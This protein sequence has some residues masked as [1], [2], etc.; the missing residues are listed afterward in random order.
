MMA[1]KEKADTAGVVLNLHQSYSPADTEADRERFG[2]VDPLVHLAEVG[3]LAP[4]VTFGH[5]NHLTDAECE[6]VLEFG[7]NLAWAPAASMMWGHGGSI[8][9]R[10]AELWRRGANVALGSDSAN[11]SNDFDLFRQANLAVLSAR[12]SHHDRTYLVAEDGLRMATMAGARAAGLADR[13]GSIEA[14]KRAD[15]VIHTLDRPEM[16]PT[17]DMVRNLFYASGSKSVHTVI[18]DGKVVLDG[19][20][21]VTVD[22]GEMLRAINTASLSLLSRM[23]KLP[24]ER[25]RIVRPVRSVGTT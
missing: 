1:A 6:R 15:I 22:E 16:I 21:F 24:V 23:G 5:A 8:H 18:V 25:N 19:G 4:N 7:P 9:G 3:F 14:G 13:I 20:R 2:G 10:H 17:T 11:W 12:D